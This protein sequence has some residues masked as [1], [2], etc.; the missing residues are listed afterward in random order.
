MRR[1]LLTIFLLSLAA[2]SSSPR[3]TPLPAGTP[4]L[5]FGDSV[6][7]GTGAGPGEDYPSRLAART[8]WV[9]TNAGI[10]GDTASGAKSRIR[11]AIEQNRPAV[12]LVELGG[13]DFLRR[14]ADSEI[15]EDLRF[16]LAAVREAGAVP[17]LV[18]VPRFSVLSVAIGA[19][20]D[21]EIYAELAKEE[22]VPLV[23][24]VFSD[25]LSDPSLKADQI[26]PTAE[27]YRKLAEGIGNALVK[28][29]LLAKR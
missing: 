18:A 13:N 16:I 28:E 1:F 20:R 27:G 6:T 11:E 24:S 22:K 4:V 25:V 9:I 14:R 3:F 15:K 5:A 23:K 7:Y 26:H 21:S 19:L 8:G 17:V 10:P 12:V 2:C 29:G